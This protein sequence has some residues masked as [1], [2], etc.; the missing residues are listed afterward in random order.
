[1]PSASVGRAGQD[2]AAEQ[3]Y[4]AR[5]WVG[6]WRCGL[7][8]RLALELRVNMAPTEPR[9]PAALSAYS[10]LVTVLSGHHRLAQ[11]G[12]LGGGVGQQGS[13]VWVGGTAVCDEVL[14][15]QAGSV[16]AGMVL[17]RLRAA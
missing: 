13:Q 2:W 5:H 16:A 15:Q 14:L 12:G 8:C 4:Y 6:R 3:P 11:E 17:L 10:P 7:H 1:M 9:S